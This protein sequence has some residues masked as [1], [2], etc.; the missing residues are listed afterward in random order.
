M[1]EKYKVVDKEIE[2]SRLLGQNCSTS[3]Q[4]GCMRCFGHLT[5]RG[6]LINELFLAINNSSLLGPVCCLCAFPLC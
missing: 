4:L 6:T 3:T 5:P 2:G 1:G